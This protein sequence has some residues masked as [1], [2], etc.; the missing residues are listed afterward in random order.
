MKLSSY[1]YHGYSL[2]EAKQKL[3]E[4]QS[5]QTKK[6]NRTEEYFDKCFKNRIGYWKNKGLNE[7]ESKKIISKN[8]N[9]TSLDFFIKKLAEENNYYLIYIWEE[10]FRKIK[11][12]L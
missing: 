1:L 12:K 6:V 7:E 4:Y 11:K 2:D 5:N 3:S 9:H 10:D 8:Q